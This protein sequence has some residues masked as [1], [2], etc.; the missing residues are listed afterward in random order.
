[1]RKIS[2]KIINENNKTMLNKVSKTNCS[3]HSIT[4]TSIIKIS[5]FFFTS[6]KDYTYVLPKNMKHNLLKIHA[7]T[8]ARLSNM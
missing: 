4:D 6:L 7:E 8:N 3:F 5:F 1:M 2:E